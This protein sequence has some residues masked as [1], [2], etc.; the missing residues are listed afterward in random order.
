MTTHRCQGSE[1]NCGYNPCIACSQW[2]CSRCGADGE[3]VIGDLPEGWFGVYRSS[4]IGISGKLSDVGYICPECMGDLHEF[5]LAKTTTVNH[6]SA[7]GRYDM[8][9]DPVSDQPTSNDEGTGERVARTLAKGDRI[10]ARPC[11]V[12]IERFSGSSVYGW[13]ATCEARHII[14]RFRYEAGGGPW[15]PLREHEHSWRVE[16][17]GEY[18]PFHNVCEDCGADRGDAPTDAAIGSSVEQP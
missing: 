10:Q 12:T 5:W 18:E 1:P 2:V 11:V 14:D 8:S 9:G 16:G 3:G 4:S 7:S 15:E 17:D 6:G 13:C